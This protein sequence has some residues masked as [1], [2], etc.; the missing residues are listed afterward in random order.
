MGWELP[1]GLAAV[2]PLLRPRILFVKPL[3]R[4][5]ILFVKP[6]LRPRILLVLHKKI[7]HKNYIMNRE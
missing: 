6:L 3:L 5:R 4:P 7:Q 1:D 2:K